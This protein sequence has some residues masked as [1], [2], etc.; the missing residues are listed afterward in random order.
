MAEKLPRGVRNKNPGNIDWNETNKWVGLVG[1]ERGVPK[2][3]FCEFIDAESGIRALGKILQTYYKKHGLNTIRKILHR[4]APGIENDT[5]AYISAVAKR[6]GIGAD[7][8]IKDIR[9]Q[10]VLSELMKAII[11]H[12]CAN[13]VYPDSVFNEGLRRALA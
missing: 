8:P 7:E 13:Y 10:K 3:R 5:P 2:P 6:S 11:R 1:I 12:E 4:Y 9:D